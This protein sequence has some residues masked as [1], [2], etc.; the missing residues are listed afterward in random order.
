[1]N[2]E[3]PAIDVRRELAIGDPGANGNGFVFCIQIDGIELLEL[4][5]LFGRIGDVVEGVS[6]S[7]CPSD[8][9]AM[10]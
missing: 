4:N 10:R 8:A 5:L 6:R 3:A 2:G 9:G 1:M 7:K